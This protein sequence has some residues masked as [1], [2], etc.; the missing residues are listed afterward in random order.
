MPEV[1][2]R[3]VQDLQAFRRNGDQRPQVYA[4]ADQGGFGAAVPIDPLQPNAPSARCEVDQIHRNPGGLPAGSA[5]L[6][7][8]RDHPSDPVDALP[9]VGRQH[10]EIPGSRTRSQNCAN[11]DQQLPHDHQEFKGSTDKRPGHA[12]PERC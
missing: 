9:E 6:K 4:L 5:N 10:P 12:Q 11:A 8:R 3:D 1:R 2:L 7:R